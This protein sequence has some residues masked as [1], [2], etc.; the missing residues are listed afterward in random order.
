VKLNV[1]RQ[2]PEDG[3]WTK[4]DGHAEPLLRNWRPSKSSRFEAWQHCAQ[5]EGDVLRFG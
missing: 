4:T 1:K 2:D 3:F 5:R